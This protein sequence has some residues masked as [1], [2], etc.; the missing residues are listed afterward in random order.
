M[1]MSMPLFCGR[2]SPPASVAGAPVAVPA[3]ISG[4]HA[5]SR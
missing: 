3:S 4:D 5:A 2:V 1:P